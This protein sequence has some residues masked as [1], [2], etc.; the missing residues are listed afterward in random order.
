VHAENYGHAKTLLLAFAYG[1]RGENTTRAPCVFL[2]IWPIFARRQHVEARTVE[3]KRTLREVDN[4]TF[5]IIPFVLE[6]MELGNMV[7]DLFHT[8]C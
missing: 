8:H 1:L 3:C 7:N 6:F 2:A 4:G 5:V